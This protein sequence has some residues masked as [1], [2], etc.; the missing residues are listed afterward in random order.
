M[1]RVIEHNGGKSEIVEAT[2]DAIFIRIL[3]V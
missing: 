3:K 2:G 1:E